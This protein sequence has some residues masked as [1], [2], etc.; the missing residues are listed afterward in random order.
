MANNLIQIK[1]TSVS[2]RA[3][4]TTTLPN[5]GELAINITDGI[6]Y[7]TN[8]SVVFEVG[9]N[10]T[11]S[12]VSGTLTVNSVSANGS[13]GAD[14]QVLTSNGTTVYWSTVTTVTQ[15]NTGVGLTGGPIDT[16]GTISVNPNTGIVANASGLFV[17]SAY[18]ATLDANN[19]SYLNGNTASDLRSYSDTIAGTAYSNAISTA[20]A[21]AT[22]KAATAYSN[23]VSTA[24]SDATSKAATAYSNAVSTSA[25][26]ATN[27]AATAYSNSVSYFSS[28]VNTAIDARVTKTFVDNLNIDAD[29]IDGL[30]STQFLRS[31][32]NDT[33][34]GDIT[35]SGN[36]SVSTLIANS[37]PGTSGQVLT[38]NGSTTYW[39]TP[40]SA[41]DALALAIALG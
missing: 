40:A 4:N 9:A 27:K 23:A 34:T 41:D 18:I 12:Q 13:L 14:G 33:A 7:S 31:D 8:G 32:A 37:S 36:V 19:A 2:G 24:S 29:T 39:T 5:P 3:A 15:V 38:S 1:R 6:M 20:S 10:N 30:D 22:S 25:T 11:N 16:T 26:D 35:F 21:D 28:N 17:N